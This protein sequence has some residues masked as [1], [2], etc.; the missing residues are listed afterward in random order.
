MASVYAL[1]SEF[2]SSKTIASAHLIRL[3]HLFS[4]SSKNRY[5]KD[6]AITFREAERNSIGSYF[7]AISLKLKHNIK[8]IHKLDAEIEEIKTEIK[9]IMDE[10]NSPILT[11]PSINYR[12]GGM[13]IAK[14][15]I[16]NHFD[17]LDKVFTYAGMTEYSCAVTPP[18][19]QTGNRQS[20]PTETACAS[21]LA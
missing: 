9:F 20:R 5:G 16:F 11:S 2:P 19:R 10:I 13:T 15:S 6:T 17:S 1:L 8:L 4:E 3:T 21:L 7:P 14:N 12:I 18:V